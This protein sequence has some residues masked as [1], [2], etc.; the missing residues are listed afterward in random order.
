MTAPT[1]IPPTPIDAYLTI[2]GERVAD[3]ST[4][5][6]SP[7]VLSGLQLTWGRPSTVDQPD[8]ATARFTI[9]DYSGNQTFVKLAAVGQ[10]VQVHASA[11]AW[12]PD[13]PVQTIPD[14]G[15]T[16]GVIGRRPRNVTVTAGATATVQESGGDN[17]RWLQVRP[18]VTGRPA[19]VLILPAAPSS[20]VGAWDHI[21]ATYPG[22]TWRAAIATGV[23]AVGVTLWVGVAEIS[24]PDRVDQAA[25]SWDPV[26]WNP[27]LG[28]YS[29]DYAPTTA[30]RWL[31]IAVKA[32]PAALVWDAAPWPSWD[33]I[34]AGITWDILGDGFAVDGVTLDAP[35]AGAVRDVTVF[36]G[37]ITD[38]AAQWDEGA[39]ACL[40]DVTAA[41]LTAD[42]TN[43][44]VGAEPWPA[45][46]L[47][48]R[49]T[50]IL[51]AA[52]VTLDV[53]YGPSPAGLSSLQVGR[54]DVDRQ[55]AWTMIADLIA[56]VDGVGWLAVHATED[57]F[58][59]VEDAAGRTATLQL[60][61]DGT[62]HPTIVVATGDGEDTVSLSAC[63]VDLEPVQ[64]VQTNADMATRVA[65]RWQD[66]TTDPDP[67]ERTTELRRDDLEA[68]TA[69]YG[70][71]RVSVG[72]Q[73][74]TETDAS[75]VADRVLTRLA[76]QD[77]WRV[78]GIRHTVEPAEPVD[79]VNT[80]LDMLDGTRRLGLGVILTDLPAWSPIAAG[81]LATFLEG[82]RYDYT[83]G[84][85]TLEMV[86]SA[87]TGTGTSITWDQLDPAWSWDDFPP[88]MTWNDLT[89]VGPGSSGGQQI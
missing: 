62:G 46:T 50:R 5:V 58:L 63:D 80:V 17:G 84:A 30:G 16:V 71:R 42:L 37:R 49:I 11:I 67:T 64:W 51:A 70:V 59:W 66:Q 88:G 2:A 85:W 86:L 54:V 8:T 21:P 3:G 45:E 4:D 22:Q 38:A 72:S 13:N 89:G 36:A 60:V 69:Q 53:R 15:F 65:V 82:G 76:R 79:L 9:A 83:D 14:P 78:A 77:G 28:P 19:T 25:I 44:D 29:R 7:V 35:T 56:G 33:E 20:V 40:V 34:P 39:G 32:D 27:D 75:A 61:D 18:D 73:L 48:A 57:S 24:A 47:A 23:R 74:T 1:F 31:A 6:Q 43:R 87:A 10:G 41:D 81:E 55:Q 12:D 52:G 68:L 26:P